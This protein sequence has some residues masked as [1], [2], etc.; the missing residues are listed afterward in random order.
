MK[1]SLQTI[2]FTA[3]ILLGASSLKAQYLPASDSTFNAGTPATGRLWGTVFGDYYYK[4][5]ADVLNRGGSNQY[6]GLAENRNAFQFRRIYLG[7]DYNFNK[8]FSSELLMAAEDNSVAGYNS[9]GSSATGDQLLSGKYAFYIKLANIRMKNIWKGTDLVIGQQSTPAFGGSSEKVWGYRAIERTIADIRRTPS[10]DLGVGLQ[11][12][13]DP[14]TKNYGYNLLIANGTSAKP[15]N[16]NNKW[17]YGDVWAKFLDQKLMVDIYADYSRLNDWSVADV[18]HRSR[19]M[20]KGFVSYSTSPITVG[21]EGFVNNLKND[22]TA[23]RI[24]GSGTD[25]L[26][27]TASG[28]SAFVNGDIIKS[29]LRYFA[30]YDIYTPT[31]QVNND[32]YNKYVLATS[33]YNDNSYLT[34]A[35]L[36]SA[37]ANPTGDQTYKQ[38]FITLGLDWM[39]TKN[40]H[41]MPNIWYNHYSTQLS[42]D[43][44]NTINGD[45]ASKAKGDYD[46]VYR[47]TVYYV[48]GK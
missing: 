32:K 13:F 18:P 16:T 37:P 6:S 48:F 46:L 44:N 25:L 38:N 1:K 11:G 28:V 30:R 39:P 17:L 10:F 3:L 9:T 24:D 43:L 23:T 47:V 21:L 2:L 35:T 34:P 14:K 41:I 29:K 8:K 26:N 40:V 36:T 20:L 33:N 12:T 19:Q 42:D 22:V 7:Y 31:N 5:H 4:S 15:S 45:L 27:N